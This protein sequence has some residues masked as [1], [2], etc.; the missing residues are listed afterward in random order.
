MIRGAAHPRVRAAAAVAA[1]PR[2]RPKRDAVHTAHRAWVT[3]RAVGEPLPIEA[4]HDEASRSL[5][6]RGAGDLRYRLHAGLSNTAL[7]LNS[8]RRWDARPHESQTD[9]RPLSGGH[10]RRLLSADPGRT[11]ISVEARDQMRRR[12]GRPP[13]AGGNH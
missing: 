5:G 7:A 1:Y 3:A 11:L 10:A 4:Y 9:Q 8:R 6:H 2:W 13:V 12:P